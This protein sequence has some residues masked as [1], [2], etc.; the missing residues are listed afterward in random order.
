MVDSVVVVPLGRVTTVVTVSPTRAS[1]GSVITIGVPLPL[2]ASAALTLFAASVSNTVG[3]D[4]ATVSIVTGN[5]LLLELLLPAASVAL[6]VK[7]CAPSTNAVEGVKVKV[8]DGPSV[9][10]PNSVLPSY[11]RTVLPAS[12]VNTSVGRASLVVAPLASE[13]V[14]PATSS[15]TLTRT[16]AAGAVVSI[17][18][19]KFEVAPLVLP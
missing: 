14:T 6:A 2:V 16:G 5:A 9:A 11:T 13:P 15:V 8:P 4:G 3:A 7:L 1:E 19:L 10:L 18:R 12:A 17:V